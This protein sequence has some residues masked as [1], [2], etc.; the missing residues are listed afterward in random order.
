MIEERDRAEAPSE[1]GERRSIVMF[2]Y[3]FPPCRCWPTASARAESLALGL[4]DHGW[5]P[6]VVT[7]GNGCACL[8]SSPSEG[9]EETPTRPEIGVRRV[10]VGPSPLFRI[11][12]ATERWYGP[13]FGRRVAYRL[14]RRVR[15]ARWLTEK[16]ND[17]P[18]RALEEGRAVVQERRAGVV[19]TTSVPY[20]SI[21]IGRNLQRR[22]RTPWVADLRDSIGRERAWRGPLDRI[23][24]RH[25]RRRWFGALRKASAVICVTP[26]EAE[27]DAKS[28]G[29][30]VHSIPS[31][32]DLAAWRPL[33]QADDGRPDRN[34]L[35]LILYTG[36]FYRDR[37]ELGDLFFGGLRRFVDSLPEPPPILFRYVGPQ[38]RQFL[39]A[40]GRNGCEDIAEDGGVVSPADARLMMVRASVLLLLTP[41]TPEGGMPGGKFYEYLAAGPPI[42]AVHGTDGYVM[43]VL[44][45]TQAG[46]GASTPEDVA[47]A[48]ARRYE[49]WRLGRAAVRSLDGLARFTW[50]SRAHELAGLLESLGSPER[51]RTDLMDPIQGVVT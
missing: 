32:F 12:A 7:R 28:L 5:D 49:D 24:G 15:N 25:L 13:T 37:I 30:E 34:Q 1:R 4:T 40:A 36:G 33:R 3:Y 16:R 46:E 51:R 41:A 45:E 47:A 50:S 31:G 39:S 14:F 8:D 23:A 2:A 42:L 9:V 29:R 38:G 11:S 19:W 26:Q 43:E 27:I 6:I 44:R 17:W 10:E 21:G 35:F 48:L 22:F 20:R 18:R